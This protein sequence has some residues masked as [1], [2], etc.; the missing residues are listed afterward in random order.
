MSRKL[1]EWDKLKRKGSA[2]YKSGGIEPI[3]LYKDL[4]P[5]PSLNALQVKGLTDII[6]YAYRMLSLGMNDKDIDKIDHYL[7][8]SA[9]CHHEQLA[10][11]EQE[12]KKKSIERQK[13]AKEEA[14]QANQINSL[15]RGR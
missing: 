5:N 6:K 13:K 8:L 9:T 3:D 4:Q 14:D 10:I 11:I 15:I 7:H 2:H 1:S 12:K